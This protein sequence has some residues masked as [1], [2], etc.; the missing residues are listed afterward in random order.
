VKLC[1]GHCIR[2][3][4][5]AGNL[6]YQIPLPTNFEEME[7]DQWEAYLPKVHEVVRERVLPGLP[8]SIVETEV[9]KLMGW[10]R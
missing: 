9:L 4:D 7:E 10:A 8:D 6:A 3:F 1:T 2:I 5:S